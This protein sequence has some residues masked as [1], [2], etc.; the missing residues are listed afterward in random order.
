M[1]TTHTRAKRTPKPAREDNTKTS[2]RSAN[3]DQDEEPCLLLHRKEHDHIHNNKPPPLQDLAQGGTRR[4]AEN[5]AEHGEPKERGL[6]TMPPKRWMA[7][8]ASSSSAGTE[9]LQ[10]FHLDLKTTTPEAQTRCSPKYTIIAS[11]RLYSAHRRSVVRCGRGCW[12]NTY[13]MML[14]TDMRDK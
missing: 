10:S 5:L 1:I 12:S 11:C 9:V 2:N 8:N 6:A 13:S 7:Q 14:D 4:R 3:I